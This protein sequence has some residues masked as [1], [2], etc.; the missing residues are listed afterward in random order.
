MAEISGFFL[1]QVRRDICVPS[2]FQ[3][4]DSLRDLLLNVA[5]LPRL[6][7][8]RPI[9]SAFLGELD[10]LST[11]SFSS[12]GHGWILVSTSSRNLRKQDCAGGVMPV[13]GE[14]G[15]G[16]PANSRGLRSQCDHLATLDDQQ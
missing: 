5:A 1:N 8:C 11:W 3:S 7:D 10:V 15:F 13:I 2:F 14:D 9:A 6:L 12:F 4:R 16:W